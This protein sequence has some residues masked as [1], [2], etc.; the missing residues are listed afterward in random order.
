MTDRDDRLDP[1]RLSRVVDGLPWRELEQLANEVLG[2]LLLIVESNGAQRRDVSIART[3]P[4]S[5]A[6]PAS[7]MCRCE[8]PSRR[9]HWD[10][11]LRQA[12]DADVAAAH[13]GEAPTP[14]R[15]AGAIVRAA[16]DLRLARRGPRE[17]PTEAEIST[18]RGP[19][20]VDY[21]LER[22]AG[23]P[24][25]RAAVLESARA[26]HVDAAAIRRIRSTNGYGIE[27]GEPRA[28][29]ADLE[30]QVLTLHRMGRSDR[31]I[32]VELDMGSSSVSRMLKG[33]RSAVGAQAA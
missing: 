3:H 28:P 29:D 9:D 24:A 14:R 11:Q 33:K 18:H 23:I 1:E 16:E 26:G 25:A 15:F 21:V 20:R 7:P 22:W 8:C 27:L 4:G 30:D 19:E 13:A 31:E 32:A 12:R 6:P 5:T 10:G 17:R 2:A